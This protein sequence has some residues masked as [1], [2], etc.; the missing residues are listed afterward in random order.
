MP[1]KCFCL[2][3]LHFGFVFL[4]VFH[5]V[6]QVNLELWSY[7]CFSSVRVTVLHHGAQMNSFVTSKELAQHSEYQLVMSL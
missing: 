7:L 3:C 4:A 5:Y 1:K 6:A 2:F